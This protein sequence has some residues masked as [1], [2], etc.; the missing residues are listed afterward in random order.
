L[1]PGSSKPPRPHFNFALQTPA[2]A[3]AATPPTAI[4]R[5]SATP[6]FLRPQSASPP[7]A[8]PEP[9]PPAE[10]VVAK[11]AAPAAVTVNPAAM[12]A[13][14][15]GQ[16][17]GESP[18]AAP[19]SPP[20]PVAA[21]A[22][23]CLLRPARHFDQV[24]WPAACLRML[25]E[26]GGEL[27]RLAE[28]LRAAERTGK[29]TIG[30]GASRRGEGATAVLLAAGRRL[31]ERGLRIAL[32]DA[33][34]LNPQLHQRLG[35]RIEAGWEVALA[36][37]AALADVLAATL[38]PTVALLPL[39]K[40][41]AV[42]PDQ[43]AETIHEHLRDL[44]LNYDLVL[45]NLGPL[46]DEGSLGGLAGGLD[47]AVLVQDERAPGDNRLQQAT[48]QLAAIR[49]AALGVVRNFARKGPLLA[50]R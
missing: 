32:V 27:D 28:A 2:K 29:K 30:I 45:V 6:A 38:A 36:G 48:G 50:A 19:A 25:S 10:T 12:A 41:G 26:S 31:A 39:C 23:L 33:D 22:T 40:A 4:A 46:A 9:K 8:P 37:E 7:A 1:E 24:A 35:L 17:P 14:D 5:K 42:L 44:R 20:P 11:T 49:A 16:E 3:A 13:L 47:A 21:P 15:A 43:C 18:S 34:W